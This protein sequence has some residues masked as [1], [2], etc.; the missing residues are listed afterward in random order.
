MAA[1][2]TTKQLQTVD[3]N[4]ARIIIQYPGFIDFTLKKV[5]NETMINPIHNKMRTAGLSYKIIDATFLS[6]EHDRSTRTIRYYVISNYNATTKKGD[7][8]PVA[9]FIEDGRKAYIINAPEPTE[10]RPNPHL[11]FEDKEGQTKFRKSV[12]IPRYIPKKFIQDTIQQNVSLAQEA[13]NDAQNKWLNENGIP[14]N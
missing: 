11:K 8:F 12:K 10:A 14:I 6:S 4:L 1:I 5:L 3:Q 9:I 13:F 2:T 7:K